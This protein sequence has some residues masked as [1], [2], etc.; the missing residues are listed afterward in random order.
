[1]LWWPGTILFLVSL[2][3]FNILLSRSIHVLS[4]HDPYLESSRNRRDFNPRGLGKTMRGWNCLKS[5]GVEMARTL[6]TISAQK[7]M[8]TYV[9]CSDTHLCSVCVIEVCS[10]DQKS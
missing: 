5:I 9:R 6:D 7:P 3:R 8:L 2:I 1:M 10:M 4:A